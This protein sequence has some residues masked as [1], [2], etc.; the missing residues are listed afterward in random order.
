M[1]CQRTLLATK[2]SSFILGPNGWATYFPSVVGPALPF[3]IA[4]PHCGSLLY[5]MHPL[6]PRSGSF[7]NLANQEQTHI[8]PN[9]TCLFCFWGCLVGFHLQLLCV[10]YLQNLKYRESHGKDLHGKLV[11]F[12]GNRY[13]G[14]LAGPGVR[15]MTP[16]MVSSHSFSQA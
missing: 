16:D 10:E 11:C 8:N 1:F 3:N 12:H 4:W 6:A 14:L 2:G 15:G 13:T 9:E 5:R 7:P